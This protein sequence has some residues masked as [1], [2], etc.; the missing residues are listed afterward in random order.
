LP[1]PVQA[2]VLALNGL[3]ALGEG[4][5]QPKVGMSLKGAKA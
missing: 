1:T 5:I 2:G 3:Y 4:Q